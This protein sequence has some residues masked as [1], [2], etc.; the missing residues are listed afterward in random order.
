MTRREDEKQRRLAFET[1]SEDAEKGAERL[2]RIAHRLISD[3]EKLRE[4]SSEL[5]E[6]MM[7]SLSV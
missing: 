7:K 1:V 6:R 4:R 3:S 5:R 2:T